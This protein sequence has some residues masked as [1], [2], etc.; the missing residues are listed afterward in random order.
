MA[1][2]VRVLGETVSELPELADVVCARHGVENV[3]EIE[4]AS[5][6]RHA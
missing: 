2:D 6:G 5:V 4:G 1:I 3:D